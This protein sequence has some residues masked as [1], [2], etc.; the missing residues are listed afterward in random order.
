MK[1][2]LLATIIAAALSMGCATLNNTVDRSRTTSAHA[3]DSAAVVR[4]AIPPVPE[5]AQAEALST[6]LATALPAALSEAL[7]HAQI[8]GARAFGKRLQR[9]K[10]YLAHFAK[11]RSIYQQTGIIDPAP[12]GHYAKALGDVSHIL[13]I[14]STNLNRSQVTL[15]EA[16][17]IAPCRKLVCKV[18][19]K[20]LWQTDLKVLAELIDVRTG[21]VTWRGVGE[22][23]RIQQGSAGL[24][25]GLVKTY[26]TKGDDIETLA[27]Q[28]VDIAAQ[29]VAGQIAK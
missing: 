20:N 29:G 13:L 3:L 15:K 21:E 27:A 22:A 25:F 6:N 4:I 8:V 2:I 24:D 28:M 9:H 23:T 17:R 16:L 12:L 5:N 1:R 7:P 10:G 18:N 14:R 19:P 11:W 26:G